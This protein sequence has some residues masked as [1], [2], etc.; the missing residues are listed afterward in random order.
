MPTH[1]HDETTVLLADE[2]EGIS[3]TKILSNQASFHVTCS[4]GTN[5]L[6]FEY[7]S[8]TFFTNLS[9]E[10]GE[11][12]F[13]RNNFTAKSKIKACKTH[14]QILISWCER[15]FQLVVMCDGDIGSNEDCITIETGS[16]YVPA[17]DLRWARTYNLLP[18]KVFSS[19]ED[20]LGSI[21]ESLQHANIKIRDSN[22]VKTFWDRDRS[23]ERKDKLIPKLEPESVSAI[24]SLLQDFS[25]VGGYEIISESAASSGKLDLL[26]IGSV[27]GV[28]LIKICIEAKNAHSPDLE[29]GV[30]D[31]LPEYMRARDAEYGIYL[32]LWYD[33]KSIKKNNNDIGLHL[34]K[35]KPMRNIL[36]EMFDL[37][38]KLSPSNRSFKYV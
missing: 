17:A 37:T 14:F 13:K 31:Q 26:I 23:G 15:R 11:V 24:V 12:I 35:I 18:K 4:P 6:F 19:K 27:K 25:L 10:N 30:T 16:I 33:F 28:G 21:I 34:T 38:I 29:H 7:K 9:S 2:L 22:S 8:P 32:V 5:G 36:I 1:K 20:F 3:V